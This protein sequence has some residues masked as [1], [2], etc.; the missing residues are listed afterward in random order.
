MRAFVLT[1]SIATLAAASLNSPL[2]AQAA[3][4][5]PDQDIAQAAATQK[6]T[7]QLKLPPSKIAP[8][9]PLSQ[10]E[11]AVQMLNRFTYGPRPGDIEQ[12]MTMGPDKWFAQQLEPGSI[13]DTPLDKRLNDYPT[14]R[15]SSEQILAIYP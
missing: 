12:V 7:A 15:L 11:R 10:R 14:L 5:K 3:P 13:P 4:A 6:A 2:H 8:R 1:L 9:V